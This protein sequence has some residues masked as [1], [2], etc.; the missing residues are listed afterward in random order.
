MWGSAIFRMG[1][2]RLF[3]GDNF[4]ASA[5]LADVCALLTAVLAVNCC[6]GIMD[7]NIGETARRTDGRTTRFRNKRP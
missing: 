3:N 6:S 1:G 5:A 2:W 7:P 4:S